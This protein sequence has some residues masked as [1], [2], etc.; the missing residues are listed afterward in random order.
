MRVSTLHVPLES[1]NHYRKQADS[2]ELNT[3][4][5]VFVDNCGQ[6]TQTDKSQRIMA[7]ELITDHT[8]IDVTQSRYLALAYQGYPLV[9]AFALLGYIPAYPL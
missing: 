5:L 8:S 1:H 7:P 9:F 2:G 6:L 4:I 3:L